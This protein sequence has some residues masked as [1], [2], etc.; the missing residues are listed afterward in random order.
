MFLAGLIIA[1][2]FVNVSSLHAQSCPIDNADTDGAYLISDCCDLDHSNATYRLSGDMTLERNRNSNGDSCFV[3]EADSVTLDMSGHTATYDTWPVVEI[4]NPS[5]ESGSGTFADNWSYSYTGTGGAQR[6]QNRAFWVFGR[7][8]SIVIPANSPAQYIESDLVTLAGGVTYR[9]HVFFKGQRDDVYMTLNGVCN[10]RYS[11]NQLS[12]PTQ[13]TGAYFSLS[14]DYTPSADVSARLR[15]GTGSILPRDVII[16]IAQVNPA[17]STIDPF[18]MALDVND[19]SIMNG[20][21]IQGNAKTIGDWDGGSHIV[22]LSRADGARIHGMRIVGNGMQMMPLQVRDS[23]SVHIYD[24][25]E[26]RT[27][28]NYTQV[29]DRH[30]AVI[31]LSGMPTNSRIFNNILYSV[32]TGIRFNGNN[33]E[34]D[35]NQINHSSYVSNG[36]AMAI[37]R[38]YNNL[39]IHDNLI[40]GIGRGIHITS[41]SG[42]VVHNNDFDLME[43]PNPEYSH[44]DDFEFTSF[45]GYCAKGIHFEGVPTEAHVYNNRVITRQV[46]GTYPGCSLS[47]TH[48]ITPGT[49]VNN[50]IENNEFI[51]QTEY[52]SSDVRRDGVA[53]FIYSN[54]DVNGLILRNNIYR[55]QSRA[56]IKFLSRNIDV[57]L[58]SPT[59]INESG[60]TDDFRFIHNDLPGTDTFR[61]FN[62]INPVV[63]DGRVDIPHSANPRYWN[64]FISWHLTVNVIDSNGKALDGARVFVQRNEGPVVFDDYTDSDGRFI[65]PLYAHETRQ[66]DTLSGYE[67]DPLFNYTLIV[68]RGD[69][70]HPARSIVMD[71]N[72]TA[73]FE[74]TVGDD[75]SAPVL[76]EGSPSGILPAGT[77]QTTLHVETHENAECRYSTDPDVDYEI[78]PSVFST[79][80]EMVHESEIRALSDGDELHYYVRCMDYNGNANQSDYEIAF[81]IGVDVEPPPSGDD[82]TSGDED[83]PGDPGSGESYISASSGS[84]A[85]VTG[86]CGNLQGDNDHSAS[87]LLIAL[88]L[89]AF[90]FKNRLLKLR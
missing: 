6:I 37:R 75:N 4:L 10:N 14:C 48:E 39:D 52:L 43:Y 45:S 34:I 66:A 26:L 17:P 64:Y 2:I 87:I 83:A 86:G 38:P 18:I 15:I 31:W 74:F 81:G 9:A 36:Y 84:S 19:V 40:S 23:D 88:I 62:F 30:I 47:L 85:L 60:L 21:V 68:S 5:F 90:F 35:H 27:N 33:I 41:G 1:L 50:T 8:H 73:T 13:T 56:A 25:P 76:G 46:E 3:V 72:R 80:G 57:V 79:T 67:I 11:V 78:M 49:T 61:D 55:T 70:I 28:S 63:F 32:Q 51:F 12:D 20:T 22:S 16:D 44:V 82:D 71:R 59:F 24:N 89:L 29:R 58:D 69:V 65:I 7:E 54:N 42:A 77:T 53:A